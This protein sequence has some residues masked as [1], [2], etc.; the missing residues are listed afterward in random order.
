MF[1]TLIDTFG[2]L[3]RKILGY[4]RITDRELDAI[5]KDIRVTLLEADVNYK[6]VREFINELRG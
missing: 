2:K 6:V 1:D 3:K 4:G 5:L